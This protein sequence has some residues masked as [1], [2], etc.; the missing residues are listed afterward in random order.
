MRT[1]Q[2]VQDGAQRTGRRSWLGALAAPGLRPAGAAEVRQRPRGLL[3]FAAAAALGLS[4]AAVSAA[5]PPDEDGGEQPSQTLDESL[6]EGLDTQLLEGL[7]AAQPASESSSAPRPDAAPD[8]ADLDRRLLQQ[9]GQGEDLGSESSDPLLS[10]GRQMKAAE[11]LISL[12]KTSE[13]ERVQRGIVDDLQ[14][15]IDQLKKQCSGGSENGNPSASPSASQSRSAGKTGAGENRGSDRP[16]SESDP[17]VGRNGGDD[18]ELA[19][20][21][22]MLKQVWGHLPERVRAQMQSGMAEEFLPQYE[23]LIEQYYR[24]LAEQ[25]GTP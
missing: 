2:Y 20:M 24:R 17:R 14:R 8:P 3:L 6:L 21:R 15:L 16:A 23:Q 9:L 10:I 5:Q 12:R 19:G 22:E 18:Q 1:T 13:S 11:E 4:S 7:D 25:R